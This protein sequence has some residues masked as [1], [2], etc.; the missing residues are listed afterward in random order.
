M[1]ASKIVKNLN[2]ETKKKDDQE[3]FFHPINTSQDCQKRF[4]FF[5][6]AGALYEFFF[7]RAHQNQIVRRGYV[8]KQLN[9]DE[10][11]QYASSYNEF[12]TQIHPKAQETFSDYGLVFSHK[13][14]APL[15]P[16]TLWK[17]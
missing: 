4:L 15:D 6:K 16:S 3:F 17:S 13:M 14:A 1:C 9:L 10:T 12:L 2:R 7:Q 11:L 8:E 5:S